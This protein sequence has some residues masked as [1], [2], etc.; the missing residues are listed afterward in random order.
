MMSNTLLK[1]ISNSRCIVVLLFVMLTPSVF[2]LKEFT[3]RLKDHLFLPSV[4]TI[5]S[6]EKVRLIIINNDETPEEIDSFELNREKVVFGNSKVTIFIG[7][8]PPGKYTFFGE[9]H[10]DTATGVVIV[11][12]NKEHTHVDK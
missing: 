11:S 3:I 12:D 5:P 8:L 10:P 7:P 1:K 6:G 9:F 4:I 2:A